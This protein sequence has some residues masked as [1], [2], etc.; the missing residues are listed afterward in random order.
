M[1]C[2]RDPGARA[3]DRGTTHRA[4]A[5]SIETMSRRDLAEIG[6][7]QRAET[8]SAGEDKARLLVDGVIGRSLE[9]AFKQIE[10]RSQGLRIRCRPR[11]HSE[12]L[13]RVE[14]AVGR[15]VVEPDRKADEPVIDSAEHV[16]RLAVLNAEPGL[17][18]K[19]VTEAVADRRRA[20]NVVA[21][22][23]QGLFAHEGSVDQKVVA[24]SPERRLDEAGT[25][26]AGE[27]AESDIAEP[28]RAVIVDEKPDVGIKAQALCTAE[29]VAMHPIGMHSRAI[30]G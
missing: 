4:G 5:A 19:D 23:V 20:V 10:A 6:T 25:Q 21:G 2:H 15:I 9:S 1:P 7:D 22:I 14:Q 3:S 28:L 26:A 11:L 29:E 24:R 30:D 13:C 18:R 17:D 8:D 12:P 16:A 27:I